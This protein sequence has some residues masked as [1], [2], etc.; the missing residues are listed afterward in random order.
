MYPGPAA[1]I[2]RSGDDGEFAP[3]INVSLAAATDDLESF[4]VKEL[5]R[6]A[7]YFTDLVIGERV[8][9]TV[10]GRPAIRVLSRYRQG[11]FSIALAQWMIHHDPQQV[12]ISAAAE[13][14]EWRGTDPAFK[15]IVESFE[16]V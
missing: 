15:T 1:L 5:K 11:R 12:T 9:V 3:N 6:A 7:D 4:I 8:R 16:F 2:A 14:A 13:E 10:A